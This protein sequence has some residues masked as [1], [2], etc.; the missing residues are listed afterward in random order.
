M[1]ISSTLE[2]CLVPVPKHSIKGS[3]GV[4]HTGWAYRSA[5]TLWILSLGRSDP[6]WGRLEADTEACRVG[7]L[8]WRG[9]PKHAARVTSFC[10]DPFAVWQIPHQSWPILPAQCESSCCT[11]HSLQRLFHFRR[12][13]HRC[14]SAWRPS[15]SSVPRVFPHRSLIIRVLA[16][17]PFFVFSFLLWVAIAL[18]STKSKDHQPACCGRSACQ[19]GTREA[20]AGGSGV[21]IILAT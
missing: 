13:C 8:H 20:K 6:L 1:P 17:V 18:S 2:A 10:F 19:P 14:G 5:S 3:Q 12:S 21:R 15:R 9:W 4:G 16:C 11:T 7:Q